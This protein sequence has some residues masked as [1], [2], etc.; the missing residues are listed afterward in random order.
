M[1]LKQ[2]CSSAPFL[3]VLRDRLDGVL[4]NLILCV[5]SLPMAGALELG[6][7]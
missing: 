3:E 6:N 4:S 5:E 2:K 7:P 1:A